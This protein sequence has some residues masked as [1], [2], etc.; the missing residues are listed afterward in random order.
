MTKK[1]SVQS[2]LTDNII[3]NT[4]KKKSSM[5]KKII[6]F[7]IVFLTVIII[8][9]ASLVYYYVYQTQLSKNIPENIRITIKK[10]LSTKDIADILKSK[11]LINDINVFRIYMYL[12]G[13]KKLQAG[14]YTIKTGEINM[15]KLVNLL[16]KGSLEKKLTF[17][18]GW[19]LEEYYNYLEK[20]ISKEFS[21]NFIKSKLIQEGYMFPD[22]YIIDLAT[23]TPDQL[24]SMM[25]NTFNKRFDLALKEEAKKKNLAEP[26]V[27]I[28][29][30]LLE[31]EMNIKKDRPIV[32]GIL[33]KRIKSNWALQV[34]ATVQY[35]LG[36]DITPWP[37]PTKEAIDN[38]VSPYNTYKNKGLPPSPICN[39]SLDAIKAV[40][41]YVDS[42]YWFYLTDKNGVTHFAKTIEEHN[43]NVSKYLY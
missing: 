23:T 34:D 18:E 20:E 7:L 35:A 13:D 30:S 16:Q 24:A 32:A 3:P 10:G 33:L 22:T 37:K 39:P 9:V 8:I 17:I 43:E 19:R 41:N 38:T 36:T 12:N 6:V 14:I 5:F 29:A 31:R 27:I 25:K 1:D 28:L 4:L 21:D 2:I 26:E 15:D 11:D 40:I 42:D